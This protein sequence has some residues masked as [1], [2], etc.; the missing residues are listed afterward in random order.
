MGE[1]LDVWRGKREAKPR[2]KK[3]TGIFPFFYVVNFERPQG[4]PGFIETSVA[5]NM[6][7]RSPLARRKKDKQQEK[8]W[9]MI[10]FSRSRSRFYMFCLTIFIC[11]RSVVPIA[12]VNCHSIAAKL[13]DSTS[14]YYKLNRFCLSWALLEALAVK[15]NARHH[16]IFK[17][18]YQRRQR[19]M[20][21]LWINYETF[22]PPHVSFC[23]RKTCKRKRH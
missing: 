12:S 22:R 13:V 7:P 18:L 20:H 21:Q 17:N 8:K 5:E 6:H 2:R 9:M 4:T 23:T 19:K 16:S 1:T 15:Q 14:N 3:S 11:S 10:D